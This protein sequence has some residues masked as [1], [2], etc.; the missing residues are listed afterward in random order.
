MIVAPARNCGKTARFKIAQA[1]ALVFQRRD[2]LADF[3]AELIEEVHGRVRK[4]PAVVAAVTPAEW[5]VI[6]DAMAAM[7]AAPRQ[8]L[9]AAGQ[10]A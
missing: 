6:D 3:E 2:V 9:T 8:D 1:L 7:L 10:A 5:A 4:D